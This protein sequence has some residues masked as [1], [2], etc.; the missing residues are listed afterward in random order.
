MSPRGP[1]AIA[2]TLGFTLLR[3]HPVPSLRW[4]C[5]NAIK[6]SGVFSSWFF[7]RTLVPSLRWVPSHAWW[8]YFYKINHHRPLQKKRDAAHH[9]RTEVDDI[10]KYF[11]ARVSSDSY[12]ILAQGGLR[13]GGL[14]PAAALRMP[15]N[16]RN[17]S[18]AA[19]VMLYIVV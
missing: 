17:I 10:H 1:G 11:A 18:S 3:S 9:Q 5:E 14:M 7:F 19:T 12:T 4:G 8:R 13:R 6:Y 15:A 16:V 2:L